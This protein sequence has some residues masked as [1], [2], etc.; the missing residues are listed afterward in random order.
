MAAQE[1]FTG[2]KA[3]MNLNNGV[4]P[5]GAV[6]TIMQSIGTLSSVQSDYDAQKILN[7]ANAME[8]CLTKSMYS[9]SA[10]KTFNIYE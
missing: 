10:T 2:V 6:K 9:L 1:T 7:I 4:S 8:Q 5:S 3:Q